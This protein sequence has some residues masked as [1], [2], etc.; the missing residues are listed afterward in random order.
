[1]DEFYRF[2]LDLPRSDLNIETISTERMS[3]KQK[4][5]YISGHLSGLFA[6]HSKQTCETHPAQNQPCLCT[7]QNSDKRLECAFF[8]LKGI[9]KILGSK[10]TQYWEKLTLQSCFSA[11]HIAI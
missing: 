2:G 8:G 1:M 7:L 9:F 6:I 3:L 5:E 4:F 11:I 10:A